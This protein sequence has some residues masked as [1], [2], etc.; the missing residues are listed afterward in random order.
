MVVGKAA[1]TA[2]IKRLE[3]MGLV[4]SQPHPDDGRLNR[5]RL[6]DKA[7]ELAPRIAKEVNDLEKAIEEAV[8]SQTTKTLFEALLI[9]NKL[10]M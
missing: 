9:I 1:A 10:D 5:L 2:M 4:T 6:T 3:V 8:G 7:R